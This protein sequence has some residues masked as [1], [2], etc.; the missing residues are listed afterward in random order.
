[1]VG[2]GILVGR[3][4]RLGNT[5][6]ERRPAANVKEPTT[7]CSASAATY[8]RAQSFRP[9]AWA[10][11]RSPASHGFAGEF[12]E[13]DFVEFGAVDVATQQHVGG[14]DNRPEVAPGK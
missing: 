14:G 3:L 12:V 6:T 9:W 7:R 2:S 1:M 8:P 4:P 10:R 5:L 11:G 13:D